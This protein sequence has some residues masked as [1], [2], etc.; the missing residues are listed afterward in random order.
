[1]DLSTY[2]K[3][4]YS[5]TRAKKYLSKKCLK[6]GHRFCL[7][8]NERK[9]YKLNDGRRRC[10]RCKY[11][12]HDFS[13]RWINHGRLSCIQWLSIIKLFEL[14]LSVHKMSEQMSL[15]YNTVYNA[16]H[17]IRYAILTHAKDAIDLLHGEI[18]LDESYFGGRRKGNRGR[19]AAGKV[20]VFGILE[21]NGQVRVTVVK[22][23]TA[24]TLINLTVK[25]V[26]RG[27]I[28]YTDKFK[29]YDSLMCCGY[30]HLKI[31]HGKRFSSGKVYIN[32]LEGFWSWA[33]ERFIKHHG[34]SK[35][36]FPLYLKELEF[37]YNNRHSDIFEKISDYLCDLVPKLN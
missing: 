20:P 3:I 12:F 7:G 19:G 30:R 34:I 27:S 26:K 32:G 9:L 28:I 15:A 33:K 16:V 18:E 5:E 23:V 36:Q 31:D 1:M 6:N 4:I 13:G 35:K 21:R 11:T 22:D 25:T 8:C 24:N 37:R 29:S 14:E 10:S 2:Y 17:T